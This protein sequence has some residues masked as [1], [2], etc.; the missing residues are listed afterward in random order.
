[1]TQRT[2]ADIQT[3]FFLKVRLLIKDIPDKLLYHVPNGEVRNV[4]VGA[5]LKR[6]GVVCGVPD[7]VLAIPNK[8][9]HSLYIEFKACNGS[10]TKEQKEFQQQAEKAGSKYVIC[11]SAYEAVKEIREYLN[12]K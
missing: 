7:V 12:E 4:R 5:K 6:M 1:M 3:E 10:Q 8:S 2:E 11:R 9:Y